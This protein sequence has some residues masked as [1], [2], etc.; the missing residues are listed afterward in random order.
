[1]HGDKLKFNCTLH[2]RERGSFKDVM[3]FHVTDIMMTG[4]NTNYALYTTP[5]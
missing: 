2:E 1:M 5:I 3:H 4:H